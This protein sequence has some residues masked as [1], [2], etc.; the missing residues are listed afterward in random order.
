MTLLE[1]IQMKD[2]AVK[3]CSSQS[4]ELTNITIYIPHHCVL[5]P[6]K[7]DKVRVVFNVSTKY[8]TFA[9][10]NDQLLK[11]L[12]FVNNLV[13]ILILFRLGMYPVTTDIQQ[14]FHQVKGKECDQDALRSRSLIFCGD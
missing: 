4:K 11:G 2:Y 6:K 12:D 13:T 5:H 8:K 7:P 10:L 14:M 3:L 9:C 1:N